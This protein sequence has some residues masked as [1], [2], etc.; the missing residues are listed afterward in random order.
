MAAGR[1]DG[2][3]TPLI[4]HRVCLNHAPD[5]IA[6]NDVPSCLVDIP[7]LGDGVGDATSDI[8]D[9]GPE[10]GPTDEAPADVGFEAE[11]GHE[12]GDVAS[13]EPP[14]ADV[15]GP[16]CGVGTDECDGDLSN[17]WSMLDCL[18]L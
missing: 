16:A 6:C 5:R 8:V 9:A 17:H 13:E 4:L 10:D 11:V 2:V 14:D 7:P 18:Y 3:V 12:A 1:R 15:D